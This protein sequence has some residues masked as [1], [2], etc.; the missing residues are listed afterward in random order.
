[1]ADRRMFSKRIINS[2]RFLKMPISTQCLYFHLGLHADDDGIVEAYN[3]LN[4]T[5]ATEDD[6]KVLVAKNFVHVLNE[7]LVTYITD[8]TE[9]NKIRADRKV[10]SIYKNLLLQVLPDT[11]L[12]E[13][14]QRADVKKRLGQPMDVQW[15]TNGQPMDGIGKDRLG[16]DSIGKDSIDIVELDK[17]IPK[18]TSKQTKHKYGEYNHVLL[19]D[20]EF[21]NLARDFSNDLRE[22]AIKFLDEYIEETGYKKK[23]HYLTIRRW[24]IDAVKEQEQ[25]QTKQTKTSKPN[26]FNNFQ[27]RSYSTAEMDALERK[28]LGL[29]KPKPL[30]DEELKEAEELKQELKEK[31][32]KG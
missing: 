29:D 15:T 11:H 6:L 8:W 4:S 30:T 28:L 17:P 27:Q 20:T 32:G 25:K 1:M 21:N 22:K 13:K 31:Y 2:A 24:V 5:G 14:K 19:T 16:K 9:N 3:V 23:S 18:Q 26:Q 10:D 7:D 12:Q